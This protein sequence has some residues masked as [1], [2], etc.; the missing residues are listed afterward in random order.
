MADEYDLLIKDPVRIYVY[1]RGI[2]RFAASILGDVFYMKTTDINHNTT[3]VNI[4]WNEF[5]QE[6]YLDEVKFDITQE[7]TDLPKGTEIV[8]SPRAKAVEWT[9]L[10]CKQLIH[11]LEKMLFHRVKKDIF[12]TETGIP[13]HGHTAV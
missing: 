2:G 12:A 8:I 10:Q 9:E 5:N 4:N 7:E 6:K 11:E 13:Q 1:V 3:R